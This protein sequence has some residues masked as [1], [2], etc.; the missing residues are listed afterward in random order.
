M[1]RHVSHSLQFIFQDSPPELIIFFSGLLQSIEVQIPFIAVFQT[2]SLFFFLQKLPINPINPINR[3]IQT[4][5][6]LQVGIESNGPFERE[7]F[8]AWDDR[9]VY[10]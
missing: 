5:P 8:S 1:L 3:V 4:E 2:P 10:V 9:F 7:G 6:S